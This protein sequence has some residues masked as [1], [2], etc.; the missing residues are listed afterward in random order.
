MK[1][2]FKI[3]I[4]FYNLQIILLFKIG[5]FYSRYFIFLKTTINMKIYSF[6]KKQN[7]PV[8]VEIAWNFL[9]DPNNLKKIT[10][11]YMGF[12]IISSIEKEMYSGQII[13]YTV[14]PLF[15]IPFKWVTEITHVEKNRFFVDEQRFGPYSFWHHK[16]YLKPIKGG[17]EMRDVI[18]YKIPL[19]VIGQIIHPMCKPKLKEIFDYRKK[20]LNKILGTIKK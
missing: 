17:V 5:F 18:H 12:N 10:P 8:S 2:I 16:H 14:S 19:G 15:G 6:E 13:Q 4:F 3:F 7:F 11:D 9:S 20:T 1:S